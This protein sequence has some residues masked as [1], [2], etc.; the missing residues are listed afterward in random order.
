VES[1]DEFGITRESTSTEDIYQACKQEGQARYDQANATPF[2]NSPLLD[3]F[4]T[5]GNQR[6]IEKVLDGTYQCPDGV[7]EY[8][9]KCI[10]E[11]RKP[12][13]L[14]QLGSI[15]R[16]ITTETFSNSWKCMRV[17]TAASPYGRSFSES[18]PV[19]PTQIFLTVT[20]LFFRLPP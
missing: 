20:P 15:T 14:Q 1:T 11:L 8:T 10:E 7:S 12:T 16:H 2:M 18:S 3:D 5:L 17:N 9:A 19:L 4:G 6:T 13:K